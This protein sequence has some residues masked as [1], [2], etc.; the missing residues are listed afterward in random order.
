M[1][2]SVKRARLYMHCEYKV[3]YI[4]NNNDVNSNNNDTCS[5]L[6]TEIKQSLLNLNFG[7]NVGC[8]CRN[9]LFD[10]KT[11]FLRSSAT[12]WKKKVYHLINEKTNRIS[13]LGQDTRFNYLNVFSLF[14]AICNPP[15][16][17]KVYFKWIVKVL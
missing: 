8:W 3:N 5:S 14:C 10:L 2:Q 7:S 1:L 15:Q 13:R 17:I 12:F 6:K 9:I 16:K 11:P 4:L